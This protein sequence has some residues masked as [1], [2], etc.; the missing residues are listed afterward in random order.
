MRGE[1][2]SA[3][4]LCRDCPELADELRRRIEGIESVQSRFA[5]RSFSPAHVTSRPGPDSTNRSPPRSF[6]IRCPHCHNPIE[7]EGEV[8]V[9]NVVC[10]TCGSAFSLVGTINETK[11]A[12]AV[13]SIAHFDLIEQI[14]VGTFGTVWKA[15]DNEL[16]R[17]VAIKIPR[18]GQLTPTETE[19]FFREARVAAQ[20]R[21]PNIVSVHEVG[22]TEDS[23]YIVSDFVRGVTLA[24][25][26]SAQR[27][28]S[29]EAAE[30]CARSPA[31]CTMPTSKAS[32]IAIS[33]RATS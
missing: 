3:E 29:R 4:A 27:L 7:A 17:T 19:Q 11:V 31:P 24:D 18:K 6:H 15:R 28:A 22:R 5:T 16:D 33:S 10:S 9:E 14:G 25:W 2:L 1:S 20:L 32:S 21:H 13:R 30:L 8:D 26:L 12:H 23:I